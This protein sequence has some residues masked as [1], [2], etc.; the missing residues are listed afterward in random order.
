[1]VLPALLTASSTKLLIQ[2]FIKLYQSIRI[3]QS[4]LDAEGSIVSER[5]IA[6][7]LVQY[8]RTKMYELQKSVKVHKAN[9]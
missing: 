8:Q 5:S 9:A 3:Y 6:L 7:E 4:I 2:N 1:M